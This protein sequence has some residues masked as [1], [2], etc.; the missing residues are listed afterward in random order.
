MAFD[1]V[2]AQVRVFWK[3]SCRCNWLL[4]C[5]NLCT[6]SFWISRKAYDTLDHDHTL[7]ILE[8]YGA[9]PHICLIICTVWNAELV[10]PPSSGGYYG[11]P[12]RA[13]RGV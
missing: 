11:E 4:T 5:V 1:T 2:V 9:G 7:S 10:F 3:L 6:R 12:F 13:W 8:A